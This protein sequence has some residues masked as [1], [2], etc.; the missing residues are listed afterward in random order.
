M[1]NRITLG[2]FRKQ[3][4]YNSISYEKIEFDLAIGG[5]DY[6]E[7]GYINFKLTDETE[8]EDNYIYSL[9]ISVIENSKWEKVIH[10]RI[11]ISEDKKELKYQEDAPVI[12]TNCG[13]GFAPKWYKIEHPV[14]EI[15]DIAACPCCFHNYSNGVFH[16]PQELEEY[17][18]GL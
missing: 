4:I 1:D 12:C 2:Q 15:E 14:L 17:E 13:G 16:D 10:I 7:T 5:Y 6:G 11:E 9:D 8:W 18:G 3:S